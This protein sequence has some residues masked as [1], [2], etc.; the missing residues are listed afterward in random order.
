L[1]SYKRSKQCP[2]LV[3]CRAKNLQYAAEQPIRR[4]AVAKRSQKAIDYFKKL[5]HPVYSPLTQSINI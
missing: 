3:S 4:V 5:G 2:S 1:R